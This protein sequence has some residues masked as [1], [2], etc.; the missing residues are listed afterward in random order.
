MLAVSDKSCS[1]S[2]SSSNAPKITSKLLPKTQQSV[3][4]TEAIFVLCTSMSRDQNKAVS[5]HNLRNALKN[6]N[7]S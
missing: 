4:L 3:S 5:Q 2:S 1:K 6:C 7:V